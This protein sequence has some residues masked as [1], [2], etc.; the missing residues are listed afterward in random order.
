MYKVAIL[1]DSKN[2]WISKFLPK[3][4][5]DIEKYDIKIFFDPTLIEAYDLVF[6]LGYTKILSENFLNI[7]HLVLVVH[8]SNLPNGKGFA[9]VQWQ[10]LEGKNNI[11]VCLI[12]ATK[13]FDSGDIFE[14]EEITFNGTELYEEIRFIQ[15]KVTFNL[16]L[17]FLKKYP[18]FKRKP[19][20]GE[21]T[22]YRKRRPKDSE[23]DVNLSLKR[24]FP[25]MRIANNEDWPSFFKLNGET[26]I[27]KIYK[28]DK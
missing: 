2:N 6:V 20:I 9:P 18:R 23:L 5:F 16:L 22:F 25:F 1:F 10:I 28:K 8:E 7:N 14:E 17:K 19:Q 26:Y 3:D 11:K 27:L 4:L 21:A 13:D 24:L 15:A 12:E